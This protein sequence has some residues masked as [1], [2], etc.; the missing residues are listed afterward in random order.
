MQHDGVVGPG[1]PLAGE[2]ELAVVLAFG[3]DVGGVHPFVLD[4]EHH[5]RLGAFEGLLQVEQ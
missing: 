1:E 3:G 5:D 4:A 2:A